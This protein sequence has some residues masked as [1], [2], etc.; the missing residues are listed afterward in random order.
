MWRRNGI[1][2]LSVLCVPAVLGLYLFLSLPPDEP[3]VNGHP[4]SYWFVQDSSESPEA[5][6]S[7]ISAMDDRCV[8]ALIEKLN[9]K[10]S[11]LFAKVNDWSEQL[12]H[13]R[14]PFHLP[15]DRRVDAA[16]F[17]GRL[18]S[19]ATSAIPAL[20]N[21]TRTPAGKRGQ[22]SD[23]R[24][25]AIAALILVRHDPVD[26][27]ARKAIDPSDPAHPDCQYAIFCL[28]TNA[29][30]CVPL[31]VDAIQKTTNDVVKFYAARELS[32]ID[33]QPERSVP[34]L[35]SLLNETNR[36]TLLVAIYGLAEFHGAAKPAWNDLAAHLN[37]PD[38]IIRHWTSNALWVIDPNAA[39]QLGIKRMDPD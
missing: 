5:I 20:E 8:R 3:I 38:E 28:G 9:W 19:R 27:C 24:G 31:Y 11:S 39:P 18:G 12:I 13:V 36:S 1:R 21:M 6:Q 32:W 29:A 35:I 15:P 26:A 14:Q 10:P 22:E 16:L 33:N 4:L 25:A 23:V 17:L 37:D 2:L 7:A 34:A 30:S